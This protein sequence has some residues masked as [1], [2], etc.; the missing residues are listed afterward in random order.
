MKTE[1]K[2]R[3]ITEKNHQYLQYLDENGFQIGK[4]KIES[5]NYIPSHKSI[6]TLAP[7]EKF[8]K[9]VSADNHNLLKFTKKYKN[10]NEYLYNKLYRIRREKVQEQINNI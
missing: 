9:F 10:V 7:K 4:F 1:T 3:I 8:N 2:Y 5:W 6:K